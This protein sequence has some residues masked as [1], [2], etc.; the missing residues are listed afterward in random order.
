MIGM[1][2]GPRCIRSRPTKYWEAINTS[3]TPRKNTFSTTRSC[4]R[5]SE[6]VARQQARDAHREQ[7]A[8]PDQSHAERIAAAVRGERPGVVAGEDPDHEHAV[9]RG[10]EDRRRE[11]A[12]PPQRIRLAREARDR[13]LRRC[14]GA[15]TEHAVGC[16]RRWVAQID[17][18]GGLELDH[19]VGVGRIF[20]CGHRHGIVSRY[21]L[22]GRGR[23]RAVGVR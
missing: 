2:S 17:V 8:Q 19:L 21:R 3:V 22:V 14:D 6:R 5:V 1:Y 12:S 15:G 23:F 4:L 7:A 10:Q 13:P 18:L 16:R 9:G 20:A 11:Q